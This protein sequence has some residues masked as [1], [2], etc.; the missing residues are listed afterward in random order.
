MKEKFLICFY[1]LFLT[2]G[3]SSKGVNERAKEGPVVGNL[4]GQTF[5]A[6]FKGSNLK[7]GDK[8]KIFRYESFDED[9][10]THISRTRPED[11]KK[12]LI[13]LGTVSS[14][15]NDNFYEI[16]TDEPKY[17]PEGSFIEKL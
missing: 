13:G 8:L 6:E 9:L 2:L 17:I 12:V 4:D 10:K 15:L 16:K 7:V 14:V 11:K 3:C 5:Q 1:L